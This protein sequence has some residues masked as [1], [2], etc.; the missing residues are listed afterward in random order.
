M[1]SLGAGTT[2][3]LG[4]ACGGLTTW[5][6]AAVLKDVVADD[7]YDSFYGRCLPPVRIARPMCGS[8]REVCCTNRTK[9]GTG[10]VRTFPFLHF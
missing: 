9:T 7:L 1:K 4:G 2:M 3:E 5:W 10:Q 6:R 8:S